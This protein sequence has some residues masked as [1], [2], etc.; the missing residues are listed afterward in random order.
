MFPADFASID[1]MFDDE[2]VLAFGV[3]PHRDV[4][5]DVTVVSDILQPLPGTQHYSLQF[6]IHSTYVYIYIYI[7]MYMYIHVYVCTF[8]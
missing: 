4:V 1:D 7:Y 3:I 8:S 6:C 2:F 5:R